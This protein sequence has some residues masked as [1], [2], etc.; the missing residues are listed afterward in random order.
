MST[1]IEVEIKARSDRPKQELEEDILEYGEYIDSYNQKDIYL[2]HPSR[3]FSETDEALR[4]RFI[5]KDPYITYKGPKLD[6]VSKSREEIETKLIEPEKHKKILKKLGFKEAAEINKKRYEYKI[7]DFKIL[8]DKV[9]GLG[10]YIEIETKSNKDKYEESVK[11]TK[12][13]AR[14]LGFQE[15]ELITKSYLELKLEKNKNVE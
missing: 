10:T 11:E 8:I 4:I 6:E 14:E 12:N 3:D 5:N 9:T 2:N 1:E 15:K 7:N 13:I